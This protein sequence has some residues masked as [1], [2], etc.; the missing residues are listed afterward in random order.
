[1]NRRR[2]LLAVVA[3]SALVAAIYLPTLTPGVV[4]LFHDD[5]L[6]VLT[7][8]SLS[9]GDR[10]AFDNLPGAPPQT[11]YPPFYPLLLAGV[12][13]FWP[14]F[15]EN[16]ILL[17]AAALPFLVLAVL[18]TYRMGRI[19]ETRTRWFALT[20]AALVLTNPGVLTFADFTLTEVPFLGLLAALLAGWITHDRS[21]RR[22]VILVFL[23]G[24]LP[25]TRSVGLAAGVTFLLVALL[26]RRRDA[27]W[28]AGAS[29]LSFAGWEL[30]RSSVDQPTNAL[31]QYYTEYEV[32]AAGRLA[33][34]PTLAWQI[35]S[36]NAAYAF[37]ATSWLMGATWLLAPTFWLVLSSVGFASLYPKLRAVQIFTVVYLGMVLLHPFT[38]YRYLVPLV[39]VLVL[40]ALKGSAVLWQF[41]YDRVTPIGRRK[42]VRF[43]FVAAAVVL[44]AGNGL[45][46]TIVGHAESRTHL[47][48]WLLIDLGYGFRGFNETFA[49]IRAN[50]EQDAVIGSLF[51]PMYALYTGRRA[52]R[53]WVHHAETYYYPAAK[54][55]PFVGRPD[56]VGPLLAQLGVTHLTLDP[57][58]GYAEGEA[59]LALI[60]ALLR[61]PG[62]MSR[63]VFVSSD[64]QHSVYEVSWPITWSAQDDAMEPSGGRVAQ[65]GERQSVSRR[66]KSEHVARRAGSA[67]GDS[68]LWQ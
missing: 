36:D 51:D 42:A 7:A 32:S 49:W 13:R 1:M 12:W 6:Y 38:P 56:E 55:E 53:P 66:M 11:K 64:A 29:F 5:A 10:Y 23:A 31:L 14:E 24:L 8:Q 63:R 60:Q 52:V 15:P 47:R 16:A 21:R 9:R 61:Q 18:A 54:T 40:S 4:G 48:G 20:A 30:W 45:V 39:P 58:A 35:V 28:I 25:L 2:V 27:G 67:D 3:T 59:A 41:F 19:L 22:T 34:N 62:V 17:K 44:V 33:D 46:Y 57:P 43:G 65:Y 68:V 50:T 26:E 37:G